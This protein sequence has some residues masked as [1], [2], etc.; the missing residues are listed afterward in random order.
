MF[1]HYFSKTILVNFLVLLF[2]LVTAV[3]LGL[4]L[5]LMVF[6]PRA[7]DP[8]AG[9]LHKYANGQRFLPL[10]IIK[11][12]YYTLT[13]YLVFMGV[14]KCV[15]NGYSGIVS[16]LEYAVLGNILL[17]IAYEMVLAVRKNAGLDT[18]NNTADEPKVNAPLVKNTP[19]PAQPQYQQPQQQMYQQPAPVP[20][21]VPTPV[22]QPVSEPVPAPVPQPVPTPVSEPVQL[23]K[24]TTVDC[25]N[26]GKQIKADARFCPFCGKPRT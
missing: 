4:I 24:S 23:N 26:C 17:R 10:P 22:P 1:D 11:I 21:P 5:H 8:S 3:G 9:K 18:E 12:T 2:G 7:K 14:S 19:A 16:F 6:E 20:Q 15:L 13:V 25:N